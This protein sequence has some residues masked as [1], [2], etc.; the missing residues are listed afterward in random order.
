MPPRHRIAVLVQGD[1]NA[2]LLHEAGAL[3]RLLHDQQWPGI[4]RTET[5][6]GLPDGAAAPGAGPPPTRRLAW[7]PW[8]VSAIR[9]IF[10]HI[11]PQSPDIQRL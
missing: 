4:G 9:R 5:V 10:P 2:D 8:R 3:A 6:L 1:R 11:P 7:Q